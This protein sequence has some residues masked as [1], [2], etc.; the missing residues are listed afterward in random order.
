MIRGLYQQ[1]MYYPERREKSQQ[2][3]GPDD[4]L[5]ANPTSSQHSQSNITSNSALIP[6]QRREYAE[7]P[8]LVSFRRRQSQELSRRPSLVSAV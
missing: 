7:D 5:Q 2:S 6:F 1:W 4:K 8:I 3:D